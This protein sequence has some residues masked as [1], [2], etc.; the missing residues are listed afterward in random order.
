MADLLAD[1]SAAPRQRLAVPKYPA[2]AAAALSLSLSACFAEPSGSAP[3]PYSD[4][5]N[6]HADA[7]APAPP[8]AGDPLDAESEAAAVTPETG[9]FMGDPAGIPFSAYVPKAGGG[10][11]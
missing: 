4:A 2:L 6:D 3:A 9:T 10:K 1:R 11:L 7:A 5:A 8:D